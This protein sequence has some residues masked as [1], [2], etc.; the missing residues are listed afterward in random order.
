MD[1]DKVER[2]KQVDYLRF[3][4]DGLRVTHETDLLE[5][6]PENNTRLDKEQL[7]HVKDQIRKRK[8]IMAGLHSEIKSLEELL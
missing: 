7:K 1:S 6:P 8:K 4:G 5:Y 2:K 3:M